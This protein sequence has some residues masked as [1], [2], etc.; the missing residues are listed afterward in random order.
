MT[1]TSTE[2]ISPARLQAL[3]RGVTGRVLTP[4]DP[5]Y[6]AARAAWNLNAHHHPAL[7]VLAESTQDVRLAVQLAASVGLGVGML[8][9]GHG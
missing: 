2:R 3:R 4:D 8:A 9:T 7:V 1:A 6:D 5:G